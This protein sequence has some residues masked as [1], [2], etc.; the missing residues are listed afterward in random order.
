MHIDFDSVRPRTPFFSESH[1][2]W[3]ETIRKFVDKE[4]MAHIDVWE[5]QGEFPRE[6]HQKA[7]AIGAL[8]LGF[9]EEY[10]GMQEGIDIFHHLIVNEELAR[11][12]SGGLIA[13][14]MTHGIG[15]PPIIA[16]GSDELKARVAPDILA[17]E[18]LICLG[19][20]EPGAGSDVANLQTK[21]VRDG[22]E[23]II[24]GQ[25][26]YITTGIRGD[27]ITLAV[28]T[29]GEGMG[30]ISLI[31]VELDRP[32]IERHRLEKMGWWCSD[33][34]EL[35]FED[36]RVPVSNLIGEENQG[37][38]GIMLNFNTERLSM[39][40]QA[41]AFAAVCIE[42]A[43]AWARERETF[44]RPL[45]SRQ[46]IRH[47]IV[48]MVA[49]VRQAQSFLYTCAWRMQQGEQPVDDVSM[50]KFICSQVMEFCAREA[51]QILGG[52]GY[53]RGGRV[54]RIYREVRVNAIGGGSEEIMKE[55][56]SR[57]LG[58]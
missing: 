51:M 10:G 41:L 4:I 1:E 48:D 27:Y 3:R 52:V 11:A 57:Q 12:G 18:K 47:K 34:A 53:M 35:F 14:L 26:T 2:A 13:G 28:R 8:G 20:S 33:T 21:A 30:G 39:S 22:D 45:A 16:L 31:L 43:V 17:G 44:G 50:L 58:I 15:L 24:N 5:E 37:F 55:L 9:P 49:K 38:M 6:L 36:V 56:A 29:G 19:I 46:V 32:G 42:D 7:A 54:E 25:K 23:Y 40:A